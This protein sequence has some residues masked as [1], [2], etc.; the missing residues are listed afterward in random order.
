MI[1]N[2]V[3]DM[4]QVLIYFYADLFFTRMEVP[5][6]DWEVLGREMFCGVEWTQTDRGTIGEA[7]AEA[8][9][10]RR[11]PQRLHGYVHTMVFDW[12]KSPLSPVPGMETLIGELKELG[13][14]IYL[15]SNA[16]ARLHEYFPRIPGSQYFDGKV[17]SAD[18]NLLKPD[19]EIYR[20]LFRKYSLKPE[21]CLFI[22]DLPQNVEGAR[23]V[24]MDGIIFRDDVSLLRRELSAAGVPVQ[25][26]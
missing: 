15:L 26:S 8:A 17:V 23:F 9:I 19:P 13:Y 10:C 24:G 5:K 1:R 21:E 16:S 22:D 6:E 12:W 25:Q 2:I 14:G 18:Y 11:L 4:G 7:E 3:F 20:T